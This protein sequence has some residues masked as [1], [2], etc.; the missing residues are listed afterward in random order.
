M[1]RI[2][3]YTLAILEIV[4]SICSADLSA[5]KD[6]DCETYS[7]AREVTENVKTSTSIQ[8]N[9]PKGYN[10]NE[11][12][13]DSI[14]LF[15]WTEI[16]TNI[17]GESPVEWENFYDKQLKFIQRNC[18]NAAVTHII[19]RVLHPNFP[20]NEWHAWD[21]R[22]TS[23]LFTHLISKLPQNVVLMFY[24]YIA[25]DGTL[26]QW[27]ALSTSGDALEGIYAFASKWNNF[28]KSVNAP[29]F[30][31]VVFDMEE[32]GDASQ[33]PIKFDSEIFSQYKLRYPTLSMV[34]MTFGFDEITKFDRYSFVDKFYLQFY[35][36]Y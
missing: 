23:P 1:G 12:A 13:K 5:C 34:G 8:H 36:F 27:K 28:L 35:D 17:L 9:H 11:C 3:D 10:T 19:I 30:N 31:G 20:S 4:A 29:I 32:T 14:P 6:R 25:N 33:Y 18:V 16:P 24:P 15:V 22:E 26:D 7:L 2:R 21:P